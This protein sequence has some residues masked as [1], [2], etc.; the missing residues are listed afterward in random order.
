MFE[1]I[2]Q[3][4][5]RLPLLFKILFLTI[6]VSVLV[7]LLTDYH[8]DQMVSNVFQEHLRKMLVRES[9][10]NRLRF[11]HYLKDFFHVAKLT[12]EHRPFL[13]YLEKKQGSGRNSGNVSF[14]TRLPPWLLTRSALGNLAVPRFVLLLDERGAVREVFSR[15]QQKMLPK[16]F[17]KPSMLLLEKSKGQAY[18]Y[19]SEQGPYVLSG[20]DVTEAGVI[21]ATLLLISPIDD[22]FLMATQK[23]MPH[24][25]IGLVDVG[26]NTLIASNNEMVL[27]A[28]VNLDELGKNFVVT[29]KEYHDY[30]GAELA[31][32]LSSFVSNREIGELSKTFLA[33]ER[34]GRIISAAVYLSVFIL[35][36][37]WI[38]RRIRTLTDKVEDFSGQA[39]GGK[40]PQLPSG[41]KFDILA[42]RFQL[43]T[44]EVLNSHRQIKEKAEEKAA[45]QLEVASKTR[46][47]ELLESVMDSLDFGV[48]IQKG[49]RL[50][51]VNS[52]MANYL[53]LVDDVTIFSIDQKHFA[54]RIFIDKGGNRFFFQ[55]T[56]FA[57]FGDEHVILVKDIS[58]AKIVE[59]E[60]Q[61]LQEE[62]NQAQKMESVGRLA[63]G[64]AHDF[65]NI[66]T[67][68]LGYAQL[69]VLKTKDA[70]PLR[71]NFETIFESGKRAADMTQQLLAFSRKQIIKPKVICLNTTVEGLKKMLG[72]LIGEDI[73]VEV[74]LE[75]ELWNI[76][77][78]QT[79]M[80]QLLMNLALN[81]RDAMPQGGKLLIETSNVEVEVSH[82][83]IGP[84]SYVRLVVADNGVG[85]KR[86]NLEHIFEPFYTTKDIGKGTGLG[87]ATVYGIVK[88]NNGD[89]RVHSEEGE[90][91]T[92]ELYVPAFMGRDEKSDIAKIKE[93]LAVGTETVLLVED[94]SSVRQLVSS[95]L[96]SLGYT[97]IEA[98][99]GKEAEKTVAEY[100]DKIDLLLTDVVMPGMSGSELASRLAK[101]HPSL[102]VLFVTGYTE[103]SMVL[104]KLASQEVNLLH[105]PL[106]PI[107]IA[108][109]VRE[110][111]DT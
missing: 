26:K 95:V 2:K 59:E 21:K 76:K 94:D 64:I 53:Q 20:Q 14:K 15:K 100:H 69:G 63:G 62:L 110:I 35:I 88:Q 109:K 13:A 52:K 106:T 22:E 29:G 73:L 55:L 104:Q 5:R 97:V 28:A 36:T 7:G 91:T 86:E 42:E 8:V 3:L 9:Q 23:D 74:V 96:V 92:F 79:Q 103:D 45:Q 70:D 43:L 108:G 4:L 105:K 1:K 83:D 32:R 71:T 72:R 82:G 80:E 87:L 16:I 30:G 78:D 60:K 6:S 38:T 19:N 40:N 49:D 56:S 39:L 48:L 75:E 41:D 89:I 46:Q 67:A 27:P 33:N 102:Q 50:E 17:L 101:S 98:G 11:D 81:A 34:K 93:D 68:I 44:E 65:N 99:N 18:I 57:F 66:L 47:L 61:R 51:P 111:L 31:V 85:I 84:G 37:L 10:E 25:L 107:S 58:E 12:A 54:E 24:R 90:G 77:A